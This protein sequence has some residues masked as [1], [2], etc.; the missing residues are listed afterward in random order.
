MNIFVAEVKS[1]LDE[2]RTAHHPWAVIIRSPSAQLPASLRIVANGQQSLGLIWF[3]AHADM[4]TPETTP[5]GNIHGMP[6]GVL[7]G[8]GASE[9]TE[10]GGF[11]PKLDPHFALMSARATSIPASAN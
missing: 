2:R 7:L 8:Y 11:S 3:D 6:L 9:L 10:I 1:S 5:S 4:N